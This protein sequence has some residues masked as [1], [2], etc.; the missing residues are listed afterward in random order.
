MSGVGKKILALLSTHIDVADQFRHLL[1]PGH[2]LAALYDELADARASIKEV[3]RYFVV[4][5]FG[6]HQFTKLDQANSSSDVRPRVHD[7]FIDLPYQIS[8]TIERGAILS[9]LCQ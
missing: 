7:L 2:V 1:S 9:S 4:T 8:D 3:T 6:D 5:Q